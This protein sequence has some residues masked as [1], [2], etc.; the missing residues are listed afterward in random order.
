MSD[1]AGAANVINNIYLKLDNASVDPRPRVLD[2][3]AHE[4]Q[5]MP[6]NAYCRRAVSKA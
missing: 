4:H 2:S 3:E 1:A 6:G 5:E